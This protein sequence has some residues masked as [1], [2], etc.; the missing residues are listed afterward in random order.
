MKR[1]TYASMALFALFGLRC[2]QDQGQTMDR[3][4]TCLYQFNVHVTQGPSAG[5]AY[6]GLLAIQ[7]PTPQT[8]TGSFAVSGTDGGAGGMQV[9]VTGQIT[10]SSI[11]LNF[12]LAAGKSIAGTGPLADANHCQMD[13]SGTASGPQP[14][15]TGTWDGHLMSVSGCSGSDTK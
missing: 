10:G 6:Q 1:W 9:P 4:G 13:S 14:G 3:A 12:M 8:I 7:S 11:S 5:L 15:D 2:N